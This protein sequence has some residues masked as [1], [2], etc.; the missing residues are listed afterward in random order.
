LQ[1]PNKSNQSVLDAESLD[2][3][4]SNNAEAGWPDLDERDRAFAVEY[5]TNGFSHNDAAEA[6][7]LSRKSGL[8]KLREPLIGA[9]IRHLQA[10]TA[11]AKIITQQFVEQKYLEVLPKLMG[12]EDV[13]LFDHKEG[14]SISAKKFHSAETVSVLRDLG[15]AAGYVAPEGP[16]GGNVHVTIDLGGFTG[17]SEPVG[18]TIEH[19]DE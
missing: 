8:K 15:K 7:G 17:Q 1:L 14:I 16:K 10:S 6:V 4:I 12:E 2:T 9:F 5:I 19:E 3:L 13:P 11:N 18:V